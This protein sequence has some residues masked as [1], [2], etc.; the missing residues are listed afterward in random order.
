MAKGK[1]GRPARHPGE[2]LSKNRTFRIRGALDADLRTMAAANRRSVSEEIEHLLE[3]AIR[4]TSVL[5]YFLK[6]GAGAE[7]LRLIATAMATETTWTEDRAA[8]ERLR[9]AL[10]VVIA[11][12][13]NLSLPPAVT[14]E[15]LAGNQLAISLF[16]GSSL[17]KEGHRLSQL[18][19]RGDT[20]EDHPI[21]K[22]FAERPAAAD[23]PP[24]PPPPAMRVGASFLPPPDFR[25][26]PDLPPPPPA[27]PPEPA[28]PL[29]KKR[30]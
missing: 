8:A 3:N 11:T 2:K 1:R 21:N 4:D 5:R 6:S 18:A 27:A 28:A 7:A 24:V 17:A 23:K 10:N 9:A 26:L 29:K 14:E 30:Q 19:E 13:A 16:R 20:V 12:I 22:F 15:A 25:L